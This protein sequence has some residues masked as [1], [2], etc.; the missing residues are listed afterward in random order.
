MKRIDAW[1]ALLACL[2]LAGPQPPAWADPPPSESVETAWSHA[3]TVQ[4]L[5]RLDLEAALAEARTGQ[6]TESR[7]SVGAGDARQPPPDPPRLV[8]IY[9]VGQQLQAEMVI[10][11]RRHVLGTEASG[12]YRLLDVQGRC[13]RARKGAEAPLALCLET[14]AGGG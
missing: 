7:A 4:E 1:A 5:L 11:G 12:S 6:G 13:L 3:P 14:L 2:G 10:D 8:A 9:G